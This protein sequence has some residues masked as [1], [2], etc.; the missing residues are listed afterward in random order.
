[1]PAVDGLDFHALAGLHVGGVGGG[2]DVVDLHG[3]AD[4]AVKQFA[5]LVVGRHR[6][7]VD[8]DDD[9]ARLQA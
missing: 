7:P 3:F 5:H 4:F 9:V 1:M 8:G 2:G 6:L